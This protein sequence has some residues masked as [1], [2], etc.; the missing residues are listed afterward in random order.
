MSMTRSTQYWRD[1]ER[2]VAERVRAALDY[3]DEDHRPTLEF[4][5]DL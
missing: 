2:Q 5:R 1:I 4:L 3:G